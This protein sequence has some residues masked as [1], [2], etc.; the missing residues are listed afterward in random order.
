MTTALTALI[1][2]EPGLEAGYR[3]RQTPRVCVLV[4]NKQMTGQ[5]L[6]SL[7][8]GRN[9]ET[10]KGVGALRCGGDPVACLGPQCGRGVCGSY[11]KASTRTAPLPNEDQRQWDHGNINGVVGLHGSAPL[12]IQTSRWTT[13]KG[14]LTKLCLAGRG[15]KL[16]A[17]HLEDEV[18]VWSCLYSL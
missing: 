7:Q 8:F 3:S 11:T 10:P 15:R 9:A 16:C 2:K 1:T 4:N 13:R 5:P 6:Q 17:M 14:A 12:C 18:S